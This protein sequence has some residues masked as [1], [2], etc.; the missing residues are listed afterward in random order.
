M[1]VS[2]CYVLGRKFFEYELIVFYAV[3]ALEGVIE[4]TRPR[5]GVKNWRLAGPLK[6]GHA[7]DISNS[8]QL[9]IQFFE[10]MFHIFPKVLRNCKLPA[11]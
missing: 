8:Q 5:F 9:V 3:R 6:A 10:L 11:R 7:G 2:A 1:A 4:H